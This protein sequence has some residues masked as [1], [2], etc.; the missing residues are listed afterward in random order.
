[1][2]E[3]ERRAVAAEVEQLL[4]QRDHLGR[5]VW[6]Q[7]SLGERCGGLSQQMIYAAQA[8]D[9]VG[10]SVRDGILRVTGLSSRELLAKHGVP[11]G[12]METVRRYEPS[13]EPV[14]PAR[15][16]GFA[17]PLESAR[18]DTD[19]PVVD[20]RRVVR[21]LE[22]D[23]FEPSQA[24]LAVAELT[25]GDRAEDVASVSALDALELYRR[26]RALLEEGSEAIPGRRPSRGS[27]SRVTQRKRRAS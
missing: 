5:R 2:P 22:E 11:A 4:K 12:A 16:G 18:T 15:G 7:A 14:S 23:G 27:G 10:P 19:V 20:L 17:A 13:E 24:K 9:G 3:P 1:V 25:F 21:A 8:P 26:A 6:T